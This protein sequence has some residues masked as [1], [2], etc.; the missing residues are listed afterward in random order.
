MC[1]SLYEL[2]RHLD[3]YRTHGFFPYNKLSPQVKSVE[4]SA[5]VRRYVRRSSFEKTF[6]K[7]FSLSLTKLVMQQIS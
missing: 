1:S 4:S 2:I 7:S 5:A 3:T 6:K